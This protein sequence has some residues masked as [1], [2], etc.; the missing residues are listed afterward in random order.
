MYLWAI[1]ILILILV[2]ISLIACVHFFRKLTPESVIVTDM[3]LFPLH[4]FTEISICCL[5]LMICVFWLM[6]EFWTDPKLR[7][8]KLCQVITN[9]ENTSNTNACGIPL[10]YT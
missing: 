4:D 6:T 7:V 10:Y 8:L 5:D 2:A 3:Q 1:G 9:N